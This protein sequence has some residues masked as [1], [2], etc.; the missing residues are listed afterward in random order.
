MTY[1]DISARYKALYGN[2]IKTCWIADVKR[3]IGFQVR[4]AHI[5]QGDTILNPCPPVLVRRIKQIIRG[6]N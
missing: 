6:N 5:R 2:T 4:R 3:Q 1:R